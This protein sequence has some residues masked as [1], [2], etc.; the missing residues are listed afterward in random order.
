M[1][2]IGPV[3][4]PGESSFSGPK[5]DK[6]EPGINPAALFEKYS[7]ENYA[8]YFVFCSKGSWALREFPE[9]RD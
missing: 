2:D 8:G 7:T 9:N 4:P 1:G 3:G 5:G 6:G